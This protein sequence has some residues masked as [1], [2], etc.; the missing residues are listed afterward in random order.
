MNCDTNDETNVNLLI[1]IETRLS[2]GLSAVIIIS[3][4][5]KISLKYN[6]VVVQN[7][8]VTV[9]LLLRNE[10]HMHMTSKM[11]HKFTILYTLK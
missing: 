1:R 5:T 3:R 6:S 4:I 11:E 2:L 9:L 7:I 10:I 8:D